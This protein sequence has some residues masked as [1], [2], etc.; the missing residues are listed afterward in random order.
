MQFII[1]CAGTKL[2]R[3]F[4]FFVNCQIKQIY[5]QKSPRGPFHVFLRC[6]KTDA[7]IALSH[8]VHLM[9]TNYTSPKSFIL[10]AVNHLAT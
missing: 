5:I 10:I 2:V 3:N 1:M 4:L 8:A 7:K 6:C 9:S